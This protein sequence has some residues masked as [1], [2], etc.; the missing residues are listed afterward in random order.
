MG[1]VCFIL[2]C[3]WLSIALQVCKGHKMVQKPRD[4]LGAWDLQ[5]SP[6]TLLCHPLFATTK[7]HKE[8]EATEAL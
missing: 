8:M 1:H 7:N 5:A 3:G 2:W 4:L 6:V